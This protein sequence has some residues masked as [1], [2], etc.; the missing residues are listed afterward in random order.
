[1]PSRVPPSDDMNQL[2]EQRSG[3]DRRQKTKQRFDDD[4][5][6]GEVGEVGDASRRRDKKDRRGS[7]SHRSLHNDD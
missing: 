3:K 6:T 4:Q 5:D 1:M 2:S 7:R